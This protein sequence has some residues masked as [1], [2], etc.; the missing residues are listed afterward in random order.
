MS[1]IA[2]RLIKTGIKQKL[3]YMF[4]ERN[5]FSVCDLEIV[6]KAIGV[7]GGVPDDLTLYHCVDYDKMGMETKAMLFTRVMEIISER[8]KFNMFYD[9][10]INNLS[11]AI[12]GE[13]EKQDAAMIVFQAIGGLNQRSK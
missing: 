8:M 2:Q 10:S 9:G 6:F 4:K 7:S 3:D 13:Q 1:D 12:A 11:N 5:C